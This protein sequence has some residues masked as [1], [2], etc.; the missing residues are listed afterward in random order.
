MVLWNAIVTLFVNNQMKSKARRGKAAAHSAKTQ[1]K[2]MLNT[3]QFWYGWGFRESCCMYMPCDA[4]RS[5]LNSQ[6]QPFFI[7]L[8]IVYIKIDKIQVI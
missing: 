8:R 7:R 5:L 2:H 3:F 4:V 1:P 6:N